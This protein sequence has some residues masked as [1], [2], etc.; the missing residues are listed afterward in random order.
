MDSVDAGRRATSRRVTA[1]TTT[2]TTAADADAKPAER[3]APAR[4]IGARACELPQCSPLP[5]TRH[6]PG[7]MRPRRFA[8]CFVGLNRIRHRGC[9][10]RSQEECELVIAQQQEELEQRRVLASPSSCAHTCTGGV[11][12]PFPRAP[13]RPCRWPP[14]YVGHHSSPANAPCRGAVRSN[15][16]VC[17]LHDPPFFSP[18]LSLS[19]LHPPP[20]MCGC[21]CACTEQQEV[22][23]L[24]EENSKLYGELQKATEQLAASSTKGND[25]GFSTRGGLVRPC[26]VGP[27]LLSLCVCPPPPPPPGRQLVS[28]RGKNKQRAAGAAVRV[29]GW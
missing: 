16:S 21:L 11:G 24:A 8:R 2:T 3:S 6:R 25:V 22:Q 26:T 18:A 12:A 23:Q 9:A 27:D 7:T 13:V 29:A 5:G 17:A 1:T 15:A 10:G 19:L 28:P 4:S 20:S 14:C